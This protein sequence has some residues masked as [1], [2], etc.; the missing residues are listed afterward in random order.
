MQFSGDNGGATSRGVSG[1]PIT[2]CG[3]HRAGSPTA[4]STP[5]PRWPTRRSPTE[6]PDVIARTINGLVEYF[7]QRFQFYGRKLEL[8]I[9]NGKGDVLKETTGGGQEGAQ[10][11][12]LK[13]TQ[14]I[15]AFADVSAV[16]AR[17]TPTRWPSSGWSTSGRRSCPGSG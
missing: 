14:E 10:A 7:N 2:V 3:A 15:E 6:S 17:C 12:A 11:D 8:V 16:S 1:E 13:V 4:S 9:Y 5:C